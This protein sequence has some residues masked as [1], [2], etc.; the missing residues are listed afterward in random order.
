MAKSKSSK[1]HFAM[2]LFVELFNFIVVSSIFSPSPKTS[3]VS[4]Q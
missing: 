2:T 1:G 3:T 4:N